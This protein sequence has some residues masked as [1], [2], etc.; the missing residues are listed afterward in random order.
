MAFGIPFPRLRAVWTGAVLGLAACAGGH[1][2]RPP[3]SADVEEAVFRDELRILASDEFEGRRPGTPG[4]DKSVAFLVDKFRQLGLKP[5]NGDSYLQQVPL[6]DITGGR[7]A[8]F[9]VSGQGGA[10]SLDYAKD[11]VIWTKRE[12][13]ESAL[14]G[15]QVVFLGYGIVAPEYSWDDYAHADVHGKTVVVLTGDPGSATKDPKAFRGAAETYY[16]R[17]TYKVEEA[18]RHGAAG[19]LLIHDAGST[20]MPWDVVVNSW[21]GPQ[22]ELAAADGYA[23]RAAIEGWVTLAAARSMFK[24]AGLDYGSLVTSAARPGFNAVP[25]GLTADAGVHN[26]VRRFNSPNVVAVLPGTDHKREYVLYTAHWDHLGRQAAEAGGGIFNGAVD[27]ASGVAGLLTLAQ[28]FTRTRPPEDRS[29]AFIAFTGTEAG[30]LGSSYY[31]DHPLF[32]LRDTVAAL[33]LDTL[34]IGGPTRDVVVFGTGNSELEEYAREAAVFQGREVRPEPDP[35]QGQYY[36]SDEFSFARG[37]IPALYA[38]AGL[39]DSARG[40][41][42]GRQQR[43]DYFA[44]RYLTTADKYS[45]EWDVRGTLEDLSLYYEVGNRLARSRRFPRFY[46]ESEFRLDRHP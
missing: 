46:P 38:E 12:A 21:T 20:G 4:E 26:S 2:H 18:A 25:L 11:M 22:F 41:Q 17:W 44:H 37:G 45:A 29:I 9:A 5:G 8:S 33:N 31:V 1:G 32:A 42:W 16:G 28:S 27:D 19:V 10:L 35:E 43:D 15:S 3:P 14:R 39:D 24:L 7:D 36:R 23:G 40:P 30:L 34:H 6:A 13:S